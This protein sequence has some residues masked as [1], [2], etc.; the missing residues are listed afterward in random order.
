M[1]FRNFLMGSPGRMLQTPILGDDQRSAMGDIL[2][3]ARQGL[4]QNK[5][6]AEPIL[7]QARTGF[8]Q[9]TVP[10]L[11]ERFTSM[12]SGGQRSSA[13][14]G[15]LGSAGAGLEQDLAS[16]QQQFN[17]QDRGQL[18]NLLNMALRPQFE[19]TY[20]ASTPGFLH[21]LAPGL[22]SAAG[23]AL[24]N[25]ALALMF[26]KRGRQQGS[27]GQDY[28]NIIPIIKKLLGGI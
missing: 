12:G 5:F 18:M 22:M 4:A 17:M 2:G 25:P 26:S 15:A 9:R 11:A 6:N 10:S 16:L 7:Q 3:Q 24:G 20:M 21:E 1:S 28:S 13:F 23:A 27:H 8:E 19:N 14:A